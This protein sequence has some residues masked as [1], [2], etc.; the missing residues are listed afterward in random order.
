MWILQDCDLSQYGISP[1]AFHSSG[2]SRRLELYLG[3]VTAD[4][5]SLK[6][7]KEDL[8]TQLKDMQADRLEPSISVGHII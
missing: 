1:L 6:E 4:A 8:E 7:E 3:H 5:A 2:L